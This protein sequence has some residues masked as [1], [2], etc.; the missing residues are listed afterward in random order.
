MGEGRVWRCDGVEAARAR[1][2]ALARG[3]RLHLEE[4]QL[5]AAKKERVAGRA[6][7]VVD[8]QKWLRRFRALGRGSLEA[9][10]W[11]RRRRRRILNQRHAQRRSFPGSFRKKWVSAEVVLAAASDQMFYSR[12]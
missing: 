1:A 7:A 10:Q 3:R 5:L 12:P 6:D 4:E 9:P 2:A 8:L 11:R